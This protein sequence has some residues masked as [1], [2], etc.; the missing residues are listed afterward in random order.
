MRT[1]VN[2]LILLLAL[3]AL[4]GAGQL[5][6]AV[7]ASPALFTGTSAQTQPGAS[8]TITSPRAPVG[9]GWG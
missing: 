9:I 8:A 5:I 3:G 4:F 6:C 2:R 7:A 1:I